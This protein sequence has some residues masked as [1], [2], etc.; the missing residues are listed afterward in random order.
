MKKFNLIGVPFQ[1]ILGKKSEDDLVEFKEIGKDV[2]KTKVE[3]IY[4]IIINKL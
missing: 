3:E 4:K 2:T 1:I